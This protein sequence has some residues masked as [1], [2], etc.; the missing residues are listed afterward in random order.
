[1]I[2]HGKGSQGDDDEDGNELSESFL[3]KLRKN[4]FISVSPFIFQFQNPGFFTFHVLS[5]YY[6]YHCY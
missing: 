1:M 5:I 2:N 3:L 4:L 6:C